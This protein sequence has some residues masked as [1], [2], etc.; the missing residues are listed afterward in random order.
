MMFSGPFRKWSWV[1]YSSPLILPSTCNCKTRNHSFLVSS[2]MRRYPL[3]LAYERRRLPDIRARFAVT[4][5]LAA[6]AASDF[7]PIRLAR[8]AGLRL[9]GAVPAL[10]QAVMRSLMRPMALPLPVPLP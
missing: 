7:A 6:A 8:T 3:L 1:P 2:T 4:E 9:L 10:K 5:G